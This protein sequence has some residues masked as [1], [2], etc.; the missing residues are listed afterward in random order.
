MTLGELRDR[1]DLRMVGAEQPCRIAGVDGRY[2]A[3]ELVAGSLFHELAREGGL[4]V[5]AF[6]EDAA[7]QDD[8][9]EDMEIVE[10]GVDADD[11]EETDEDEDAPSEDEEPDEEDDEV[12]WDLEPLW[13]GRP[14]Y[15][16]YP[17]Q[18]VFLLLVAVVAGL[19]LLLDW[20]G[21][22]AAALGALWC[23]SLAF[24]S[25]RRVGTRYV[26]YQRRLEWSEPGFLAR[27]REVARARVQAMDIRYRF[28][29]NL[30]GRADLEIV[31]EG[32]AGDERVVFRQIPG[33]RRVRA[34]WRE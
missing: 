24:L 14:G 30:L 32:I 10:A 9:E 19:S 5:E 31:F 18:L 33:A 22:L 25:A 23:L 15:T 6:Q 27:T 34:L 21:W 12:D 7:G 2:V 3:G 17:G 8:L 28:P 4:E 20:S 29:G 1:L 11:G 26:V 13:V 16:A